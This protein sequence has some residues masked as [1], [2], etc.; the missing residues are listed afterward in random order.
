MG[1]IGW[2]HGVGP[3][4][5]GKG[6]MGPILHTGSSRLGSAAVPAVNSIV[7]FVSRVCVYL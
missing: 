7:R 4:S 2:G 1:L 5:L 3:E 6:C